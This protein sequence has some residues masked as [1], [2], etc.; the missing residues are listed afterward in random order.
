MRKYAFKT[1]LEVDFP[2]EKL[3]YLYHSFSGGGKLPVLLQKMP[4]FMWTESI[5]PET[6]SILQGKNTMSN[7]QAF[8]TIFNFLKCHF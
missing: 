1:I 5:N 6:N 3:W 7:Y 4:G 2:V 8:I